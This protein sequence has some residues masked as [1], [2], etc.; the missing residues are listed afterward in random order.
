MGNCPETTSFTRLSLQML[1]PAAFCV[2][3]N[4]QA[5]LLAALSS[6]CT[7]ASSFLLLPGCLRARRIQRLLLY[8][9]PAPKV[10]VASDD[11]VSEPARLMHLCFSVK[12]RSFGGL[13]PWIFLSKHLK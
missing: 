5:S 11:F 8:I 4:L 9:E 13:E 2:F 3:A 10:L 6:P 7:P 1:R 12:L